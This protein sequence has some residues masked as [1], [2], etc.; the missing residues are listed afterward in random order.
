MVFLVLFP[1]LLDCVMNYHGKLINLLS[2]NESMHFKDLFKNISKH[3]RPIN[4]YKGFF[5]NGFKMRF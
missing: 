5:F 1:Y 2:L 3:T 4:N